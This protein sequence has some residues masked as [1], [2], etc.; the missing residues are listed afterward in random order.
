MPGAGG[1][2]CLVLLGLGGGRWASS[3]LSSTFQT[4][5]QTLTV[6]CPWKM[7]EA[8]PM[9]LLTHQTVKRRKRRRRWQLHFLESWPG[10]A[11]W[12]LAPRDCPC[13]VPPRVGQRQGY[14]LSFGGQWEGKGPGI[15]EKQD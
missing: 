3:D 13:T 8:A 11:C 7:T 1:G 4:L 15:P 6:T 14:G 5:T 9:P 10:T 12:D 2:R